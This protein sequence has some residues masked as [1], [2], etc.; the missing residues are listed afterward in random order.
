MPIFASI[1]PAI[2]S[3][4]RRRYGV[5]YEKLADLAG[6][7]KKT[8]S[9]IDRVKAWET[10]HKK[11]T[12]NQLTKLSKGLGIP[13]FQFYQ[14]QLFPDPLTQVTDFRSFTEGES[15][16]VPLSVRKQI[17]DLHFKRERFLELLSYS[18][19]S[20]TERI[21]EISPNSSEKVAA[22]ILRDFIG[23]PL[24]AQMSWKNSQKAQKAWR[25]A[26]EGKDILLFH[27]PDV[28]VK[29]CR[30][31]SLA[32]EHFPVIAANSKDAHAGKIFSYIHELAHLSLR[33]GSL[34]DIFPPDG[35]IHSK[36]TESFCNQVAANFLLPE[37]PL[38]EHWQKLPFDSDPEQRA[39]LEQISRLFSVSRQ[40]SLIR[41]F[42]L[43]LIS[44]HVV[45]KWL[46]EFGSRHFSQ[47]SEKRAEEKNRASEG[48][49]S[50]YKVKKSQISPRYFQEILSAESEGKISNS[51]A[52][53]LLQCNY[54]GLD[55]LRKLG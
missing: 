17:E 49:P 7:D 8:K 10:G 24:R 36:S 39:S 11:V 25:A 21:P 14:D 26:I 20:S 47:E 30:G 43:G 27:F 3:E 5:S 9:R 55:A 32:H 4:I 23:V 33:A 1:A 37:N 54:R 2:F 51:E 6:I 45:A 13:L 53:S 31:F 42:R 18:E 44:R 48:G 15:G 35:T 50:Y 40:V 12:R 29:E 19:V 41:L 52:S 22:K 16:E 34:C 28:S 38:R 46:Q